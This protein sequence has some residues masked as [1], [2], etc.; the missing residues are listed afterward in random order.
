LAVKGG[1]P[2]KTTF[3]DLALFVGIAFLTVTNFTL[4]Y[5]DEGRSQPENFW[6]PPRHAAFPASPLIDAP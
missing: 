5:L 3:D 4:G 6:N 2:L 1:K